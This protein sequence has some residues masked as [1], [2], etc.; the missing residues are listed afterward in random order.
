MW[1]T[2]MLA[3]APDVLWMNWLSAVEESHSLNEITFISRPVR[4]RCYFCGAS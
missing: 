4:R 1:I 2:W 3:M